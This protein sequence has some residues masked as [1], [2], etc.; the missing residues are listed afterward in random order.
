[1]FIKNITAYIIFLVLLFNCLFASDGSAY[2]IDNTLLKEK[3]LLVENQSI[4]PC[5]LS[6][7]VGFPFFKNENDSFYIKSKNI[8]GDLAGT[9]HFWND[10]TKKSEFVLWFWDI[11][12]GFSVIARESDLCID[13][14]TNF[15][16]FDNIPLNNNGVVAASHVQQKIVQNHVVDT[17]FSWLIWSKENGLFL[18]PPS[19][20]YVKLYNLNEEN[21]LLI[22][23]YKPK[24]GSVQ[25]G[26]NMY[27]L[28][29][30]KDPSNQH[31]LGS[32]YHS[33]RVALMESWKKNPKFSKSHD[34]KNLYVTY[35]ESSSTCSLNDDYTSK[36]ES[37]LFSIQFSY[38]IQSCGEVRRYSGCSRAK[39]EFYINTNGDFDATVKEWIEIGPS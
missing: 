6:K 10:H 27:Y 11:K 22:Q 13:G 23:E 12:E 16:F 18:H 21:Y 37:T 26:A 15:N 19:S 28:V 36:G 35:M 2:E 4:A 29:D 38:N 32:P 8:R 39:V 3:S 14:F 1:M 24:A 31:K 20:K 9:A 7:I 33:F 25:N 30:A 5:E 17:S 34:Y